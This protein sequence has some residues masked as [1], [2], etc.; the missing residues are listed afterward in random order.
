MS[1]RSL[2]VV[3]PVKKGEKF[4]QLNIKSIRPG[5]GISP[6][7]LVKILGGFASRDIEYGEALNW[8]MI[9]LE[10]LEKTMKRSLYYSG[11]RRQ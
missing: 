2:H 1:R 6:K 8:D 10:H 5:Y 3:K 4:S 9:E 7:F 11:K